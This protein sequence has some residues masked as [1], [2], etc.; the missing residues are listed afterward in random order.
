MLARIIITSLKSGLLAIVLFLALLDDNLKSELLLVFFLGYFI[1]TIISFFAILF[2]IMS[3]YAFLKNRNLTELEFVK[4]TFPYYAVSVFVLTLVFY[5]ND[6]GAR[7]VLFP[8]FI[9]SLMAWFW[10]FK[11]PQY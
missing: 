9:T 11:K 5:T 1:T 4:L 6:T 7:I 10:L 8:A 2:T 3:L